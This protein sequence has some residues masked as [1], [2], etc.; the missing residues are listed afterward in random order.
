[1]PATTAPGLFRQYALNRRQFPSVQADEMRRI[2]I[3][4]RQPLSSGDIVELETDAAHHLVQV[5]R[6]KPGQLVVLFNGDGH[7]FGANLVA[8]G[9]RSARLQLL[10]RSE[11]EPEPPL[12]IHL[13]LGL[14][15]GERMDLAVQK[16]VELGVQAITPLFTEHCGV[17]LSPQRLER[18]LS[19]WRAI[20]ISAC[21]QSGRCR[22][23]TLEPPV[24]LSC[25]LAQP[26]TESGIML[27]HRSPTSL[28]QIPRPAGRVRLLVGP[29]GGLSEQERLLARNKGFSAARL[30]P[31]VLRTETA[32]LA[33]IAAVQ[34]LWGD[35]AAS[36]DNSGV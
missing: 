6:L 4:T 20:A 29:E 14:S 19:H 15:R 13:G 27:D 21:E 7:E 35:F 16:S 17:R 26:G 3:Y 32:P 30:G 24:L 11:V 8:T 31:R 22:L 28:A 25:W 12:A 36:A 5:L 1:M 18:R 23:P 33:A 2:R 34:M 9:K 10:Q